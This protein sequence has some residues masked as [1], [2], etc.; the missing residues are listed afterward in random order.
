MVLWYNGGTWGLGGTRTAEALN[1]LTV[2]STPD[3]RSTFNI[4]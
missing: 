1:I 3:P 4:R 2:S